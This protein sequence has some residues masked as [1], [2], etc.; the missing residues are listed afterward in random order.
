MGLFFWKGYLLKGDLNIV[1]KGAVVKEEKPFVIIVPSFNNDA[2]FKKNLDSIFSQAYQNYQVIYIDDCSTDNTYQ[3]VEHYIKDRGK[4][5]KVTLI[6][7]QKNLGALHN[8][9]KAI[10]A[11]GDEKIIAIVDGDDWLAH[12]SVLKDL[13]SYYA[14]EDVWLTYGQY[15]QIPENHVGLS[16]PVAK[17]FLKKGKVRFGRWVYSHLRTFY[18]GLFKNIDLSYLV[19][20][21]KFFPTTYDLAIMYPMLEMAREHAYFVPDELYIYNYEN[22]I[23]DGKIRSKEQRR[24]SKYIR[25]LPIYASVKDHPKNR[26]V[27]PRLVD[28]LVFSDNCPMQLYAFL[29]SVGQHTSNW[30]K[31]AVIYHQD[32]PFVS[33]YEEV[34]KAFPDVVFFEQ[35]SKRPKKDFK[36]KVLEALFGSFGEKSS[37]VVFA[38]DDAIITDKIDMLEGIKKLDITK[39]YGVYYQLGEH[40]NYCYKLDINQGIPELLDVSEGFLAWQF[41]GGVGDWNHS[42][43]V[44][45]VLYNKEDIAKSIKSC[46]FRS[47]RTFRKNWGKPTKQNARKMGL[48]YQRAKTVNIP[49]NFLAGRKYKPNKKRRG[50]QQ[51][52]SPEQLNELFLK[53]LKIDI[54][55]F[56]QVSNRGTC[57]DVYPQFIPRK[58]REE[59]PL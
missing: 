50:L 32:A 22:P 38:S 54:Q 27:S 10:H 12:T 58:K 15:R 43:S 36:P 29:E 2:Y 33:G 31:I 53:G 18:A 39:A 49:R 48:C 14:N 25:S 42:H 7:N 35:S 24:L 34:K 17:S 6:H 26:M 23:N 37:H 16:E 9:Y 41:E 51:S 52:F 20:G 11:C 5:D 47:L 40:V 44:D 55:R 3:N 46:S 28:L 59:D 57:S 19:K 8:I 1:K 56:Y 21:S 45:F 4:E 30:R 13:N